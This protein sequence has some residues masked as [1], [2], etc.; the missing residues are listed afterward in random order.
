MSDADRGRRAALPFVLV[1]VLLDTLGVG[2]IIP[3]GPRLVASFLNDDLERASHWFGALFALYSLM[4][5]VFAPVLGGLSD[6]FGRRAVI[7]PSLLGAA[8]SYLV[9]GLA[10]ALWWLFLGR[11]VAGITGASFSAANAYVADITPPEKR[12]ARFGAVGA[13]FGLGFILGPWLGGELGD[14]GLRVPYFVAG[15]LN[16]L[17]LVYGFFVLPESLARENRRPFSFARANP[18]GSMR[19]LSKHPVVLRLTGTLVCAFM[20]QFV[21]QSTWALSNQERFGWS[22]REVG[23]SLMAVGLGMAIVQGLL[24][25]KIVPALGER[26]SLLA[27]MTLAAAGYAAIGAAQQGWMIYFFIILLALGGI[28]GP[29]V[30]AIISSEVGP[31]EQGELQGALNSLSGITAIIGPII[32]TGLLAYFAPENASPRIPGAPFYAAAAFSLLGML[33]AARVF[34]GTPARP[35]AVAKGATE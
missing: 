33:L 22:L 8:C 28:A 34:A 32:G 30:Q 5:F 6:R 19:N 15:G 23:R 2:L 16:F 24:V 9:S 21:L 11:L 17:N 25:R 10:P 26:K 12:A 14:L 27:G 31:K 20:A 1:T 7:L 29:A 13:V 3:V 4:Q 18:F 35:V